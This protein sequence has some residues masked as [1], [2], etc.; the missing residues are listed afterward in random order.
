MR[1]RDKEQ[2]QLINARGDEFWV[3]HYKEN[4]AVKIA[5]R[6]DIFRKVK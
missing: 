4:L 1:E 6:P 3:W 5:E 2:R